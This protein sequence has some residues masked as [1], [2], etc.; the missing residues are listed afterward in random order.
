MSDAFLGGVH[1]KFWLWRNHG[2]SPV[3][4]GIFASSCS[5][6][7]DPSAPPPVKSVHAYQCPCV[8]VLGSEVHLFF[9]VVGFFLLSN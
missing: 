8:G 4:A 7:T 9:V 5:N 1:N 6:T 2:L 3:N